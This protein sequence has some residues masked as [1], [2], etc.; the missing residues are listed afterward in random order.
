MYI[1]INEHFKLPTNHFT[2]IISFHPYTPKKP[3]KTKNDKNEFHKKTPPSV[4]FTASH[5]T[6]L[7][8]GVSKQAITNLSIMEGERT[9]EGS[10]KKNLKH[11]S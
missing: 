7:W 9:K 5:W 10:R 11:C 4:F 6:S 3:G 1:H 8:S 2:S